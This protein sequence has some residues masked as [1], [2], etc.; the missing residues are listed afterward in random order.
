MFMRCKTKDCGHEICKL[1][2]WATE[3][4]H[5]SPEGQ[6]R[7][8]ILYQAVTRLPGYKPMTGM[9]II[10]QNLASDKTQ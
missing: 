8:E 9:D 3:V 7:M 2:D 10:I 1:N 6:R 4:P 5:E